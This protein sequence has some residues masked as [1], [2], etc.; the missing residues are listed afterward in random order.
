[1]KPA[2]AVKTSAA[3]FVVHHIAVGHKR[4]GRLDPEIKHQL[5]FRRFL[6]TDKANGL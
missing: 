2:G 4:M 6:K 1:M 3:A 5:G